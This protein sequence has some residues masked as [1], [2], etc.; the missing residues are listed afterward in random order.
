MRRL[1]RALPT[2][3]DIEALILRVTE[4]HQQ[5]LQGVR[6]DVQQLSERLA[7]GET[8]ILTVEE[9]LAGVE[10]EQTCQRERSLELQLQIKD[11]EDRSRRQNVRIRGLHEVTGPEDL[12]ATV[13]TIFQQVLEAIL[14]R[15]TLSGQ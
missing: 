3:A 7:E 12:R 9:R 15:R 2:R 10:Q 4:A 11:L 1:L 13:T 8:T 14:I 5:D 6:S